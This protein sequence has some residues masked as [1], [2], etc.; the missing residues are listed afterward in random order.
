MTELE[1]LQEIDRICRKYDIHYSLSGGTC[2]GQARHGGFIPWDD[3]I[4]VDMTVENYDKFEA[5]ALKELDPSKFFLHCRKTDDRYL[6]SCSRLEIVGTKLSTRKWDV[7]NINTGVFVDIF[8]L[9]YLPDNRFLR[10]I[11]SSSLFYIRCIENF[12][13]YHQVARKVSSY[14]KYLV[15]LAAILIPYKLI[16]F[17]EKK[18][19]RCCG[20]KKTG[21][22]LD[23]AIINGNTGGFPSE[24]VDEYCDTVFENIPIMNKAKSSAYLTTIYGERCFEWLPPT[25]RVSH[26]KWTEVILKEEMC[27]DLPKN[28]SDYLSIRYNLDKLEQMERLSAQMAKDFISIC[29]K[30]GKKCYLW[31]KNFYFQYADAPG[32]YFWNKPMTLAMY[33]DDYDYIMSLIDGEMTDGKYFFQNRDSEPL[34]RYGY[35]KMRLNNTLIRDVK[36][37]PYID[38]KIN[39]GFYLKIIPLDKTSNVEGK[40]IRHLRINNILNRMFLCK[41]RNNSP[42]R[43]ARVKFS[44]KCKLILMLPFSVSFLEKMLYKCQTRYNHNDDSDIL[45]NCSDDVSKGKWAY[46]EN[47]N[48]PETISLFGMDF[49]LISNLHRAGYKEKAVTEELIDEEITVDIDDDEMEDVIKERMTDTDTEADEMLAYRRAIRRLFRAERIISDEEMLDKYIRRI[50]RKYA[51]CFLNYYDSEDYQLSVL[52]YDEKTG[53]ILSNEDLFG[54]N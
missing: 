44:T 49:D 50:Q 46:L 17:V 31:D 28:Y 9:S 19:Q 10:K 21:W 12:K 54:Y 37:P 36:T 22:I 15:A 52:R 7:R 5:A 2:L 38:E 23:D 8:Q 33:R 11:V 14:K 16:L 18:L 13:M 48:D 45:A 3:D 43:F 34:Y 4:D 26:H 29:D 20:N 6:R 47:I 32:R 41:Y 25:R 42:R 24:G 1:G 53:H 40:R 30:Y 27:K 51:Y 39:N 35:T